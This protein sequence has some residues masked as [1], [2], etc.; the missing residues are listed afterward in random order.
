VGIAN[1]TDGT[2]SLAQS[3]TK[4]DKMQISVR[5]P[6]LTN[7]GLPHITVEDTLE[8]VNSGMPSHLSQ[9]HH[10][11]VICGGI[12]QEKLYPNYQK[13]TA[14]EYQ[15]K[16]IVPKNNNFYDRINST[17]DYNLEL[18]AGNKNLLIPYPKS[19][20]AYVD[21]KQIWVGGYGGVIVIDE[22]TNS[23]SKINLSADKL[24]QIVDIKRFDNYIYILDERY[25]YKYNINTEAVTK[26]NITGLPNKLNCFLIF[27]NN[28][29]I[30][31]G[32]TGIYAR[33]LDASS[34]VKVLTTNDPILQMI[35]PDSAFAI[36][37]AS[38]ILSTNDGVFME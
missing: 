22:I 19:I 26:E 6:S 10:A 3:V 36:T 33:Q 4:Y 8:W 21:K 1:S 11:N 9:I 37:N 15:A 13:F 12:G 14:P 29:I 18:D 7:V 30:V 25:I 35:V 34:F 20:F 38:A 17:I 2:L 31:G 24:L 28:T 16:Y 27:R 5:N 23:I 32:D